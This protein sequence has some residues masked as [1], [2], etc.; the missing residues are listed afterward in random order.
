MSGQRCGYSA[1]PSYT[2][3]Q[4]PATIKAGYCTEP[5]DGRMQPLRREPT[6]YPKKFSY[7]PGYIKPEPEYTQRTTQLYPAQPDNFNA[8]TAALSRES[9]HIR[10]NP[11]RTQASSTITNNSCSRS[12]ASVAQWLLENPAHHSTMDTETAPLL[13]QPESRPGTSGLRSCQQHVAA[14]ESQPITTRPDASLAQS[15]TETA[16]LSTTE[17]RPGP[18]GLQLNAI[19][20]DPDC[21]SRRYR[22]RRQAVETIDL[23]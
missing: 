5:R 6:E 15:N 9:R 4:W 12:D 23:M 3:Q 20:P 7:G 19:K 1:L 14:N 13:S 8:E 11:I 10:T 18:S 16:P 2:M 22:K 17:P 21:V